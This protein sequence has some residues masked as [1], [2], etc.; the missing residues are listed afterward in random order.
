MTRIAA[1]HGVPA[2]HQYAQSEITEAFARVCGL[3]GADRRNLD[4]LHSSAAVATRHLALPI[5]DYPK[6]RGFGDAND[7]FI[8]TALD[9]GAD[10]VAGALAQA[11]LPS[12][13][14]DLLVF[15]STTGVA[16]PS[17]DARLVD[18]LGLRPDV[19]RLP[20]FGLGCVGGAAGL[21]RVHDYLTGWPDHVAVLLSVELC[22]LTLQQTD[23]SIANLVASALFGDGAAAVVLRGSGGAEPADE[24]VS[25]GPRVV[26]TRS[27]VYPDSHRVMAWDVSNS[28]F[29]IVLGAEVPDVVRR[30][31][32]EDV[33]RFLAD[34]GLK[35]ADIQAWVCHP[36]GPKVLHAVAESLDLPAGALDVT[37]RSLAAIGNL[38]SASVLYVLRDTI[39]LDRHTRGAPGLLL[40]LGPGFASELVLLEW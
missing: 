22:S 32:G 39:A 9:L 2:R 33:E 28:G 8:E 15:T 14:V 12:T 11:G 1:V 29:Q 3:E 26:A 21:A 36:G 13:A 16:A 7:A 18:R 25:S 38:S 5:E 34:H 19:K 24:A 37:W 4:R 20:L 10:A 23:T 35:P 30:Y 17:I 6:L 40:A 31:L 27:R